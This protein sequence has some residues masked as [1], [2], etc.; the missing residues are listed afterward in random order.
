MRGREGSKTK[1][2]TRFF[3]FAAE[4]CFPGWDSVCHNP[5]RKEEGAFRLIN[6]GTGLPGFLLLSTAFITVLPLFVRF[7]IISI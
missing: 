7:C 1:T 2:Q 4:M 6:S 5:F 3:N